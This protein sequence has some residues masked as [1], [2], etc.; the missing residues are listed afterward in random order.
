MANNYFAI[1]KKSTIFKKKIQ[2]LAKKIEIFR[3]SNFKFV[4][5]KPT[6]SVLLDFFWFFW[7]LVRLIA[8]SVLGVTGRLAFIA[9]WCWFAAPKCKS[10]NS[11]SFLNRPADNEKHFRRPDTVARTYFH[12][13]EPV[14]VSDP[15]YLSRIF[16]IKFSYKAEKLTF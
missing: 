2:N 14:K 4:S 5:I 7:L 11:H 10:N 3:S 1:A 15:A 8:K 16:R 9:N 13:P 12:C 6:K